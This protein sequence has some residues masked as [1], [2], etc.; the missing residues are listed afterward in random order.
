MK[1][2]STN[3]KKSSTSTTDI[4]Y[5]Y[6]RVTYGALTFPTASRLAVWLLKRSKLSQSEIAR[7]CGVSQPCVCQLAAELK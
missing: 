5:N 2:S 4:P 6:R 7:R 1:Q 3:R